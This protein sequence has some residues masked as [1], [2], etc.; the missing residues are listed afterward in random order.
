MLLSLTFSEINKNKKTTLIVHYYNFQ[1][2][3]IFFKCNYKLQTFLKGDIIF[4]KKITNI[5]FLIKYIWVA[6]D[7][8]HVT[9]IFYNYQNLGPKSKP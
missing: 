2:L 4:F 8:Y 6:F 1:I 5:K 9:L 7:D 3:N